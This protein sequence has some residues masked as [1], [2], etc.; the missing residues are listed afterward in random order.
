MT[1][2]WGYVEHFEE[3]NLPA[4]ELALQAE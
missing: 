4:L 3:I 1:P 2:D